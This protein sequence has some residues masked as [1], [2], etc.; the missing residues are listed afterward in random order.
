M[1]RE[2]MGVP[3]QPKTPGR[4]VRIPDPL[5]AAGQNAAKDRGE[6]VS[7]ALR[8]GLEAYVL[9]PKVTWVALGRLAE[10]RGRSLAQ[11]IADAI[12]EHVKKH[13]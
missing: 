1:W 12:T 8:D 9:L 3:N 6:T 7:D 5:W 10:R 4:N 13:K 11:E 2:D